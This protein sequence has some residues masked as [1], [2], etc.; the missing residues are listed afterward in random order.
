M[1]CETLRGGKL[2]LSCEART[3]LGASTW[4]FVL[5]LR[6]GAS[7]RSFGPSARAGCC[8]KG[9]ASSDS[10]TKGTRSHRWER[11]T[12]PLIGRFESTKIRLR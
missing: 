8:G 6:L 1:T 4:C 10:A 7:T 12:M 3:D 2:S 9:R 11:N 5:V